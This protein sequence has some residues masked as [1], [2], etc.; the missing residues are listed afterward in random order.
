M[1]HQFFLTE[2][3]PELEALSHR[4]PLLR[5][6]GDDFYSRQE[7]KGLLVG[8]YEQGRFLSEFTMTR[9]TEDS[10]WLLSAAAAEL[11]DLDVLNDANP[12]ESVTITN[13]THNHNAL[14]IAGPNS[15]KVLEQITD[16]PLDNKSFPWL[17]TRNMQIAGFDVVALRLN[18]TG[19]LG[20]ELHMQMEASVPV[21]EAIHAAG[22]ALDIIDFGLSATES[23]RIEKN[24]RA[25][26]HELHTEFTVL[27]AGLDRFV[28]MDKNFQGRDAIAAQL[29]AG[30]RRLLVSMS[31]DCDTAAAHTGDPI[32]SGNKLVGVVTSGGYG[33]AMEA[34]IAM[35]YVEPSFADIGTEVSVGILGER[36]DA[37]VQA[38]PMF[39]PRTNFR[40]QMP[41]RSD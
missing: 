2:E 17:A 33:F 32:Y 19:E 36:Y 16:A 37:K 8:I 12:P 38:E 3:L 26:K 22:A 39:D 7:H 25:W 24:Y 21:Y 10:F 18:F 35:G 1:E 11:Y 34:N 23:M 5:D 13:L 4:V 30:H 6:P 15:R 14:M 28:D 29:E 40:E 31:V 20:W 41:S 9:L 27:E